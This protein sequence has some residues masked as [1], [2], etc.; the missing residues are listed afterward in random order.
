MSNEIIFHY[1][2]R[3]NDINPTHKKSMRNACTIGYQVKEDTLYIAWAK[4]HSHVDEWN[5]SM[6]SEIV[7]SRLN[8]LVNTPLQIGDS[9]YDDIVD[10]KTFSCV[11]TDHHIPNAVIKALNYKNMIR[12][13]KYFKDNDI[14]YILLYSFNYIDDMGDKIHTLINYKNL[15]EVLKTKWEIISKYRNIEASRHNNKIIRAS[16]NDIQY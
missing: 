2:L 6:G 3:T 12:P 4:P 13:S 15:L 9:I 7:S 1:G 11:L 5:R 16:I 8:R 10:Y 14:K